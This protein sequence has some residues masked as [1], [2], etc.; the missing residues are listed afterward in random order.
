[1]SI[2]R[3]AVD[4]A[5]DALV[6]AAGVAVAAAEEAVVGLAAHVGAAEL[7]RVAP[8][9]AVGG[10][11]LCA[12]ELGGAGAAAGAAGRARGG[13]EGGEQVEQVSDVGRAVAVGVPVGR[14]AERGQEREEVCARAKCALRREV[15]ERPTRFRGLGALPVTSTEPLPLRSAHPAPACARRCDV[16]AP[17]QFSGGL[18]CGVWDTGRTGAPGL[19]R[20]FSLRV[21]VGERAGAGAVCANRC[22]GRLRR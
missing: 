11:E 19:G 7:G 8:R 18:I 15:S 17:R 2:L 22:R 14:D 13:A 1:M 10:V 12:S 3:A 6:A 16:P 20:R 21:M 9:A 5:A 4:L